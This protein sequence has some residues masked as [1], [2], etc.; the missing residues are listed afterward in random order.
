MEAEVCV[1]GAGAAG[2]IMALELGRRGI[3]VVVLESG[4][5]HDFAQRGQ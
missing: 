4:P 5:R 2:G 1:V 3:K